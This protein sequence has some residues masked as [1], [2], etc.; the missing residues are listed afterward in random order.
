MSEIQP[1][2]V[3]KLYRSTIFRSYLLGFVG[4]IVGMKVCDWI[5]Y[6]PRKHEVDV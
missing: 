3:S 1:S 6:D 4:F 2:K 5:F